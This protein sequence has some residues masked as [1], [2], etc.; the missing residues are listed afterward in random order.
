MHNLL[1]YEFWTL[2]IKEE[3]AVPE[4]STLVDFLGN[5]LDTIAMEA[6]LSPEKLQ[7]AI[8]LVN[9]TLRKTHITLEGLQLL[10]GFLSFACKVIPL[11]EHLSDDCSMHLAKLKAKAYNLTPR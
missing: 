1:Y 2:K 7:R 9:Q 11:E 5:E 8:E 6:R 3:E 4:P 10:V